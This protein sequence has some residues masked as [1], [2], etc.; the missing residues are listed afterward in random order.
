ML[1][2]I[3]MERSWHF[4]VAGIFSVVLAVVIAFPLL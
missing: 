2:T 4:V 1:G 3:S